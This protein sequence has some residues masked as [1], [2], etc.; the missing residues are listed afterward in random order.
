MHH[1]TRRWYT[2]LIPVLLRRHRQEDLCEFKVYK[3]S[4]FTKFPGQSGLLYRE[5]LS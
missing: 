1:H 2:F 5:T 3:A 4:R